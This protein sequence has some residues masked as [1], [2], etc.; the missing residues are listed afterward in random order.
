MKGDLQRFV[1]AKVGQQL[2][3]YDNINSREAGGS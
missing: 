1:N 3:S 2:Y